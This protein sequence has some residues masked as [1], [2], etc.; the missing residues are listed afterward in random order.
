[1]AELLYRLGKFSAKH[2]WR[3]IVS[4]LV[5]LGLAVAGLAMF[6]KPLSSNITIPGTKASQVLDDLEEKLPDFG[7]GTGMVLFTTEDGSK[8][9]DAQREQIVEVSEGAKDLAHVSDV[10]DPFDTEAQLT[11]QKQQ[12]ADGRAEIES[13]RQQLEDGQAQL[14]TAKQQL[15][16]GEAQLE[17]GQAQLD[18]ARAQL[19]AA[20]QPATALDAQQAQ[21][22]AQRT[23]LQAGEQRLAD[24]QT[25]L[26]DGK[27]ELEAGERQLELGSELAEL[28]E[29]IR[30]V[31]EDGTTAIVNLSFDV[32]AID[33]PAEDKEAIIAYFEDR[34]IDGVEMSVSNEI[35]QSI[36][37][38][39]GPGEIVG[40]LIAAIVL[41]VMLGTLIGA[42]FPLITALTGVGVGVAGSL[43]FSGVIEMNSVTPVL[44]LMLGLAVGLDYSLFILNRHRKQLK[45]GLE[46]VESAGLANGTSGNA[47]VFA[48]S[49]VIIAL[50]ALN[51]CGIP[52]L[53]VMGT[54]GAV[55]V[56]IAVLMAVTMTPALLGLAKTRVLSKKD[57]RA[58][59]EAS[60]LSTDQ[61]GV[62][63]ETKPMHTWRAVLTAVASI[64]ALAVV[65]LP[66]LDMRVGLPDGASEPN[67]EYANTSYH[68]LE[69]KFGEGQNGAL[70]ATAVLPSG[71]SEDELLEHQVDIARAISDEGGVSAVAPVGASDDRTFTA[72][73]VIPDEGPNSVS[74]EQLVRDLRALEAPGAEGELGVSGQTAM[75]IDISQNLNDALP[76][77]LVVVVG[78]SLLIMIMVFRSLLV[79]LIA[80]GGFVLSLFATYGATTAVFQWGWGAD[81]LGIHPGPLLSFLPTILVGILFGLAMD[82]QLFLASGMREA[83]AHGSSARVAVMKGFKAGRAVVTAAGLIMISVFGGFV[84]SDMT[85]IR[86]IGFG[87]A[88]G[89]LIDA[90]VVRMLLMPALM[91][92]VGKGAWWLPK[93]L[94]KIIPNVDVEGAALERRHH[95]M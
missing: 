75:N 60:Q 46:V 57:R 10:I 62:Q 89:V 92:L 26:D 40:V 39:V 41:I 17:T 70:I 3:V 11:H 79:P 55:C 91:H 6:M 36:P 78:L 7:G 21:L 50:L 42:A 19:E 56:A 33:L 74:T 82:Y 18:D 25:Q 84:F 16:D 80:T 35:A 22:D 72:F 14:D 15:T 45:G 32:T 2:P 87:L 38:I 71:L 44:G 28:A 12:L 68:L 58:R 5:I 51:V 59:E 52:F 8:L 85:M 49:T 47:V 34:T 4:W 88:F 31:S 65:A 77:Y 9:T 37:N 24:Q 23:Q 93:W 90:F 53:G 13:G 48:G 54:V 73:Q 63:A 64:A 94:D 30:T 61:I 67:G 83:Y 27:A 20:G 86:S 69:D 81:L 29:G 95:V 76:L 43:A 66:A 1:M